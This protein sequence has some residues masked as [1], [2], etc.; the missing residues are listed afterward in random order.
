MEGQTTAGK[1]IAP[2]SGN[3][4]VREK[5][6]PPLTTPKCLRPPDREEEEERFPYGLPRVKKERRG[7]ESGEEEEAGADLPLRKERKSARLLEI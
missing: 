7:P 6:P 3:P 4:K 1:G 5:E 2:T